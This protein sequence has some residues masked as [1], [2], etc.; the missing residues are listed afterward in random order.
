MEVTIPASLRRS[1]RQGREGYSVFFL[2][3]GSLL[4]EPGDA[5]STFNIY[6]H[7]LGGVAKDK[8]EAID[9]ALDETNIYRLSH[10]TAN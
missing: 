1:P 4:H 10:A 7:T 5:I 3:P 8:S 9:E 6:V 2:K